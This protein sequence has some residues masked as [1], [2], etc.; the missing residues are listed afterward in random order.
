[1]VNKKIPNGCYDCQ[2]RSKI[3]QEFCNNYLM[4]LKDAKIE[5]NAD[6]R[7]EVILAQTKGRNWL[8][9]DEITELKV[10]A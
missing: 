9:V 4:P 7:R 3:D 8:T 1:M 10:T 2:Y 6:G 5:C